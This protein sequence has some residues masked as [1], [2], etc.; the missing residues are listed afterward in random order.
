MT[1]VGVIVMVNTPARD[2]TGLHSL[3]C[4]NDINSFK[5]Q[6]SCHFHECSIRKV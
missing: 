6:V 4:L 3:A 5:F 2:M 1:F